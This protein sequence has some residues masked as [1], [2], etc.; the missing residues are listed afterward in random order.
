MDV[1]TIRIFS[2]CGGGT[3]GYGSNR[4]MQ[5]FLHQWGIPQ[6]D[7][8]KYIDVICGTSIGSILASGYAYGKTPDYMEG[9]FLNNAKR[10]FTNRTAAEVAA[11]NHNA[12]LD[13]N[14]PDYLSKLA[15]IAL[16]TN[17]LR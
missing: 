15:S 13:S 9:F 5:K 1:N 2:F 17:L 4:F 8:W 14:R 6:T 16:D 11:G 7:F 12:S 10:I 3:K